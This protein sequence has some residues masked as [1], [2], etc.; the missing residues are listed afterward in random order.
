MLNKIL[1]YISLI[2]ILGLFILS[3]VMIAQHTR[4]NSLDEKLAAG[5]SSPFEQMEMAEIR[6][7]TYSKANNLSLWLSITALATCGLVVTS[8]II[9]ATSKKDDTTNSGLNKYR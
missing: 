3:I 7:E 2:F 8:T 9:D 1:K 5:E 6:D 4:I